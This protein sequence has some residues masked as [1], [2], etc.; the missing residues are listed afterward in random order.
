[1]ESSIDAKDTQMMVVGAGETSGKSPAFFL[2]SPDQRF[3]LKTMTWSDL[4]CF[5]S[6]A[7]SYLE[8]VTRHPDTWIS[9]FLGLY[10]VQV[11]GCA[12][13]LVGVCVVGGEGGGH[14][15]PFFISNSCTHLSLFVWGQL[16]AYFA[17]YIQ[18]PYVCL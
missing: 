9:K 3:I 13:A 1:M 15:C 14:T 11:R 12:R 4:K 17:V 18:H 8:H 10:T 6:I 5:L 2:L 16:R 7:A